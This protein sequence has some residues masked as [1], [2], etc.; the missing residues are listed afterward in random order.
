MEEDSNISQSKQENVS[1]IKNQEESTVL[2]PQ[3]LENLAA[4]LSRDNEEF[5]QEANQKLNKSDI[6][7]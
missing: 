4:F 2:D 1:Q 5:K 6:E 7:G 3:T